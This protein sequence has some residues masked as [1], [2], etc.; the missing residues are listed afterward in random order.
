[1]KSQ[2]EMA[3]DELNEVIRLEEEQR[4][5]DKWEQEEQWEKFRSTMLKVREML[6]KE[7]DDTIDI[8]RELAYKIQNT[9]G[10]MKPFKEIIDDLREKFCITTNVEMLMTNNRRRRKGIP[11]IRRQAYLQNK[12]K[13][14]KRRQKR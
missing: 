9:D 6:K 2:E 13:S 14:R 12:R 7:V 1:M 3:L 4:G 10:S 5:I 11:M 8:I